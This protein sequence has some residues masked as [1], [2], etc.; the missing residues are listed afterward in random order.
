MSFSFIYFNGH[1]LQ[2][3]NVSIAVDDWGY[4]Y[5]K[6]V[7]TTIR[8]DDGE[9]YW[10]KEH[11]KRLLKDAAQVGIVGVQLP[12]KKKL[13][14][15]LKKNQLPKGIYKLKL[16][17][18]CNENKIPCVIGIIH[19]YR[20]TS[21]S[22]VQLKTQV[23]QTQGPICQ[24]KSLAYYGRAFELEQKPLYS[25][26]SHFLLTDVNGIL[27]E[28]LDSNFFWIDQNIFYTPS[29]DLFILFGIT[30]QKIIKGLK[31]QGVKVVLGHYTKEEI[32]SQ[33]SI[34]L[35]NAMRLVQPVVQMDNTFF[36]HHKKQENNLLKILKEEM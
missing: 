34:Y 25:M 10:Y 21:S 29:S 15:L 3:K 17:I 9:I 33:A 35:C 14:M 4:Q 8:V 30:L 22:T 5:G 36:P 6:G 28:T 31:K 12:S 20:Q 23:I 1:I 19:K 16:I 13:E 27:L 7:F 18:S 11:S 26:R 32:S 24:I 2:K